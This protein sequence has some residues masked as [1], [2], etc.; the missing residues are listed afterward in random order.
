MEVDSIDLVSKGI[1][2]KYPS[3]I[4]EAVK[5]VKKSR[6]QLWALR[7]DAVVKEESKKLLSVHVRPSKKKRP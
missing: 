3:P 5:A 2:L 1:D 6:E 7:K 4:V